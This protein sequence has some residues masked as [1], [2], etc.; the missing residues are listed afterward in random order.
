MNMSQIIKLNLWVNQEKITGPSGG[1][2]LP[3]SLF[4]WARAHLPCKVA[5]V[6][7][8]EPP[9][10][11]D[12]LPYSAYIPGPASPEAPAPR[13]SFTFQGSWTSGYFQRAESLTMSQAQ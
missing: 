10:L 4:C 7:L 9:L 3:I 12:A 8:L 13:Q 1:Q 2:A 6:E 5:K 11:R